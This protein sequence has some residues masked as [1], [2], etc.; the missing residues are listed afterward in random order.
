MTIR[1]HLHDAG[2]RLT[3]VEELRSHVEAVCE[4]AGA[5]LNL[6]AVD[7]VIY[8]NR[9]GVIPGVGCGGTS[10][11]PHVLLVSVDPGPTFDANWRTELGPTVAHE[12][13]HCK[14]YRSSGSYGTTLREAIASEGLAEHFEA[15][16]RGRPPAYAVSLDEQELSRA[17]EL[18]LPELDA[19]SYDHAKWFFGGPGTPRWA[20]YA[21]GWSKVEE[22]LQRLKLDAAAAWDQPAG[23]L[24][25]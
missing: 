11:G 7:V 18:A 24:V 2:E 6:N 20:A 10:P 3:A 21:L 5:L 25:Y 22:G 9:W 8:E 14:R 16:F 15:A 17:W 12:L 13:H 1:V 23:E 4:R 19:P